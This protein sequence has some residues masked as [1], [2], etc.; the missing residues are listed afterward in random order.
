MF[1]LHGIQRLT[2]WKRLRD[3]IETSSEPL[4][5]CASFWSKAPYVSEFIDPTDIDSWP[6]PWKL[7]LDGRYDNLAIAL[8]M[9]YT[10]RLTD[11][12][13]KTEFDI[14]QHTRNNKESDYFLKIGD[15]GVL[16]LSYGEVVDVIKLQDYE[17]SKVYPKNPRT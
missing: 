2:A 6:D 3:E 9:L 4:S 16:N 12:F 8:G 11:K 17:I 15:L 10:L 5:L 7:I 1:D 13:E 14:F